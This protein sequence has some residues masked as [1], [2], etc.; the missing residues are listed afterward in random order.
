MGS[1]I[2]PH[3]GTKRDAGWRPF[4]ISK[5]LSLQPADRPCPQFTGGEQ[6]KEPEQAV[7]VELAEQEPEAAAMAPP[8]LFQVLRVHRIRINVD[9][10]GQG[11]AED[12]N[13]AL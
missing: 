13:C 3:F 9:L 11:A 7:L 10:P 12:Q 8:L 2:S 5:M 4:F 1:R 6:K